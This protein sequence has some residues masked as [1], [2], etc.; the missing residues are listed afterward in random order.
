MSIVRQ[1]FY[2]V[3]GSL[4]NYI[5]VHNAGRVPFP[6]EIQA[7]SILAY[8]GHNNVGLDILHKV[9]RREDKERRRL[10]IEERLWE[11]TYTAERH[12][13]IHDTRK[14]RP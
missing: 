3:W 13:D 6:S 9:A 8:E 2:D 7:K 11:S 14:R 4:R 1:V 10:Y 5:Q 12:I